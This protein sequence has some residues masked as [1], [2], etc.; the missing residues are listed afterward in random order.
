MTI[1]IT[2]ADETCSQTISQDVYLIP[3]GYEDYINIFLN[4]GFSPEAFGTTF[5]GFLL[6][7]AT[8]IG[9]GLILNLIK[10]GNKI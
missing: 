9:I 5:V 6:I 8:G 4:G 1:L 7:W 3:A 2:C 10:K